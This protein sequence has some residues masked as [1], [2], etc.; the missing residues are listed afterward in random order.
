MSIP[1]LGGSEKEKPKKLRQ[2]L[3][4]RKNDREQLERKMTSEQIETSSAAMA[5]IKVLVTSV[6]AVLV[7]ADPAGCLFGG[8]CC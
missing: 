7:R 3:V 8:C 6:I 5:I 1:Q 4:G 2:S